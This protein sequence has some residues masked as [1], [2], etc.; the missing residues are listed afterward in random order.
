MSPELEEGLEAYGW[1]RAQLYQALKSSFKDM[2][3]PTHAS[4]A[5]DVWVPT[6]EEP[7][8]GILPLVD[9]LDSA[10]WGGD[11]GDMDKVVGAE[12]TICD[13]G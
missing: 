13:N 3:V 12:D 9:E 1:Q 8:S 5:T 6:D 11:V 7:K 2:W 10:I 4:V